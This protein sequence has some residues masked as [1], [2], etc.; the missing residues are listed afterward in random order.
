MK[1]VRDTST[2]VARTLIEELR[3]TD[4]IKILEPSAGEGMIID[5]IYRNYDLKNIH[6]DCV[7]LNKEKYEV[8]KSKGYNAHHVDFLKYETDVKYDRI[9]AAPPFKNNIDLEHIMRMYSMLDKNGILVSLTTPY[10]MT[11]NEGH[12]IGFRGWLK[13][14]DYRIK[15]LPDNS[16]IEKG[17]TV[18]T[19]Y[20]KIFKH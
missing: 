20:I 3:L 7:E 19:A 1:T 6:I 17:R 5:E 18:A 4:D 9:I 14:K 10:W 12:Q 15:M 2:I 8:L 11:N 13:N 16:F